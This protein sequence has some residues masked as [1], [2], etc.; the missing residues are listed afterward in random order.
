MAEITIEEVTRFGDEI[1]ETIERLLP[2][3]SESAVY[4]RE[5]V[6]R[7]VESEATHLYAAR[8]DGRMAGVASLV[9]YPIPTGI[10]AHVEDVVV[11]GSA[12][13][14]GL[15]RRLLAHLIEEANERFH[16]RTIDLTSR[17]SREAANHLYVT[18]GFVK[19]DTNVYRWQPGA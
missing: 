4:D 2:A 13:G 16:A 1:A 3:L 15:S 6:R 9:V 18:S 12:R 7:I 14:R 5:L 10:R 8:L 19:R 17:P 11:D